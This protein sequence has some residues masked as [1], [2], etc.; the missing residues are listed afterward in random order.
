MPMPQPKPQAT[1]A[2]VRNRVIAPIN[3]PFANKLNLNDLLDKELAKEVGVNDGN[4]PQVA[5]AAQEQS[6]IDEQLNQFAGETTQDAPAENSDVA[7]VDI[8]ADGSVNNGQQPQAPTMPAPQGGQPPMPPAQN[9]S[10]EPEPIPTPLPEQQRPSQ[11][12]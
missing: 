4:A 1:S 2:S 3:D 5:S 11:T 10:T 9:D 7:H 8:N 6:V 12:G